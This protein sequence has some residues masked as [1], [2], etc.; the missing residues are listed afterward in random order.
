MVERTQDMNGK[1][2]LGCAML[3]GAASAFQ[4]GDKTNGFT[5]TAVTKLPEVQGTLVRMVYDR[6]GAQLA[7]LDRD[8]DNMTFS[9]AFRTIPDDDTGVAHII[10]HSVLCGSEKYPVKEP[11]V[12]L[13]KS[14]FATF[15][16]AWTSSDWTAYPVCSRNRTDFSN[17]VDVY[18]D[19]VLHPLSVKSPLAFRQ[20]GWHWELDKADGELK[21]NGVVYSEMKGAFANPERLLRHE[22]NRMLFPDN[23]YRFVSGGDPESIP[24]LTFEK[25]K[26]FY[27]KHYHPSNAHIFLDGK[28]D[29]LAILAKLD[30]ALASYDRQTVDVAVPLQKPVACERKI[31]YEIGVDE[32]PADKTYV[33]DAWVF[34]TYA[35]REKGLAFD[36]LSDVLADSNEA[37]LKK[38]LLAKGLCEDVRLFCGGDEQR[39]AT[40]IAKNVRDGKV[41][42]V[43]RVLRETLAEVAR[44]GVDRAR[45]E[46]VLDRH[47]F[48][49]REMDTG[50]TPRGLAF[51]CMALE[52]WYYAGKPEPAFFSDAIYASL[53]AKLGTGWWEQFLR[54][55]LL[56]NPHHVKLTMT[57]SATLA[58]QRHAAEQ[59][60]LKDIKAS[61]SKEQ[62]ERTR[63][64]CRELDAHQKSADKPENL[65]KLPVL[66]VKDVPPRGPEHKVAVEKVE[67]VTVVAPHTGANGIT[68][69]ELYFSLA[70][71]TT[72]ELSDVPFLADLLGELDTQ[73]YKALAL[74]SELEGKLG[75]FNTGT[76]VYCPPGDIRTARPYLV[77]KTSALVEKKDEIV[78]LAPE[79]LLRTKYDDVNAVG[80]LL[81]QVRRGQERATM[82]IGARNYAF[83]RAR[84]AFSARGAVEETME[85]IAQ[86]RRLQ[87]LD[88]A[89]AKDGA[90]HCRRLAALAQRIFTRDRITVC[91][92]DNTPAAWVKPL[93]DSFPI[94]SGGASVEHKTFAQAKEGFRTPGRVSFAAKVSRPETYAGSAVVAA[95]ILTLDYLWDAIRVQGGAYGGNFRVRPEGDGGYLSWNDPKPGRSLDCYDRSGDALRAFAKGD[96]ALDRYIVSAVA[97]TEPYQTPSVETSRAVELFLQDRSYEDLQRLRGEM[98]KTTKDD[99]LRFAETL[100]GLTNACTTCVIG[101]GP[102]FDACTNLLDHVESVQ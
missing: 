77:V 25:Y 90:A 28:V 80:D 100:D 47:Q 71:L 95:R 65:S 74:R 81:R 50:G 21:R 97:G 64:D 57:P 98:L 63:A 18:L 16:N 53:R 66:A 52:S 15:L 68:Y 22:L 60:A 86:I 88:E 72:E 59:K 51:F 96:A 38:A 84:A 30:A 9:I 27:F 12:E 73:N 8:D 101:G 61:W 45:L 7:W 54:E 40:F 4:P 39:T 102:G 26:A 35:E 78:R 82:G 70:D 62:T 13:L 11:F 93:L 37:P 79:V 69:L 14:S 32:K 6:N 44:K 92:A 34:G 1:M 42:E 55:T 46:A 29:L 87:K 85:G 48:N 76:C 94:G 75:R 5:V 91:L 49:D 17:L 67:G 19:A 33:A 99:L 58:E 2:M 10:E 20:E 83:R 56:D 23:T 36:V 31:D 3:A 89:F 43:R 41:D 24:G